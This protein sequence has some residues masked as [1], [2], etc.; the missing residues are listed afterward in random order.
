MDSR[1][2][3]SFCSETMTVIDV[4]SAVAPRNNDTNK[5]RFDIAEAIILKNTVKNM[6]N[7]IFKK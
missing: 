2:S 3:F 4:A 5:V 1:I 7:M 6:T